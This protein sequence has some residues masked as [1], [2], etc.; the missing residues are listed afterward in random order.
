MLEKL[1]GAT[2]SKLASNELVSTL[3]QTNDIKLL[4]ER[5]KTDTDLR[6]IFKSLVPRP[7]K[8]KEYSADIDAWFVRLADDL[9]MCRNI[10]PTGLFELHDEIMAS[11]ISAYRLLVYYL[12]IQTHDLTRINILQH[13]L[14]GNYIPTPLPF[15]QYRTDK[16]THCQSSLFDDK[17]KVTM[18]KNCNHIIACADCENLVVE[19]VYCKI[20]CT[21]QL[22]YLNVGL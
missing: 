21:P 22:L 4:T 16:C 12:F 11:D 13:R 17:F 15:T 6:P 19:C 9:T 2:R 10:K 14:L 5:C 3:L 1:I 18:N 20:P 8:L 7:A